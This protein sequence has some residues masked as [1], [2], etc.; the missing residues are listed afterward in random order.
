MLFAAAY[1]V[2]PGEPDGH[3]NNRQHHDQHEGKCREDDEPLDL[4][5]GSFGIEED[6]LAAAGKK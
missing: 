6:Q 4:A 1:A 2:P 5:D 3:G